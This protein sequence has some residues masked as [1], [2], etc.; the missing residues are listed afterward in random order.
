ME[1]VFEWPNKHARCGGK[2]NG[3][4]VLCGRRAYARHP[5][6][7][8]HRELI[9]LQIGFVK[10][11]TSRNL[12]QFGN[13]SRL[14][15][16]S[17]QFLYFEWTFQFEEGGWREWG[18]ER[19]R[20]KRRLI[21]KEWLWRER[22]KKMWRKKQHTYEARERKLFF[23]LLPSLSPAGRGTKVTIDTLSHSC[24]AHARW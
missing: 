17:W 24:H 16:L 2:K 6:N 14:L 15:E 19:S 18:M 20:K 7:R 21:I 8:K 4:D 23:F 9:Q 3:D 10:M 11:Q 13:R 22:K 1:R 5:Y 12:W